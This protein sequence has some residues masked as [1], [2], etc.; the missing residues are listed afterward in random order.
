MRIA[1]VITRL[2]LGGAQEN[3]VLSCEDLV[4][5]YNDDV[6]L[7]T[8]PPLGPEG[9]LLDRARAGGVPVELIP[10]LRR[11]IHPV[12]DLRTARATAGIPRDAFRPLAFGEGIDVEARSLPIARRLHAAGM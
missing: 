12:R 6:L 2:I 8:G 11:A 7:V 10:Y 1:H 4:R 3:T 5:D 9:S